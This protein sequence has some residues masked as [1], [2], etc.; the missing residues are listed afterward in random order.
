MPCGCGKKNNVG[1]IHFMGRDGTQMA[2]P[3]EWGPILWK[4]L[5]CLSEKIGTSGNKIVD[6]DQANYME[7]ILSSLHLIIP[8]TECQ[9]HTATYIS[10]N[11]VPVLKGL[12]GE[13]LRNTLRSWLLSFHNHVR[14]SKGQPITV[15]NLEEYSKI[16]ANCFVPKCEH[17]LLVQ[18]VAYAVRQGWVRIATWRKW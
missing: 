4:F 2:D 11:S 10:T 18:S 8:C 7:S 16:Y 15:N 5:H 6:A 13:A 12:H 17:T 9:A 14:A 3:L 1:T